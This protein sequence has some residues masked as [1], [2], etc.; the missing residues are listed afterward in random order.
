MLG[1]AS[2]FYSMS[3]HK[4]NR[5]IKEKNKAETQEF[6]WKTLN[7]ERNHILEIYYYVKN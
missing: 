3:K 1:K 7:L 4:N 2:Q 5:E 6:M